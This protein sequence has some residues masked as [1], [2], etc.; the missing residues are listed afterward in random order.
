M[1]PTNT[2]KLEQTIKEK[3]IRGPFL[4]EKLSISPQSFR[5]KLQGKTEFKPSEMNILAETLNL[6]ETQ[7]LDIFF[8]M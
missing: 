8:S 4:A 7:F 3:G 6:N 2:Q 5:N 1:S